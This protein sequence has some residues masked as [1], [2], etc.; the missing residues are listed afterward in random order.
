MGCNHSTKYIHQQLPSRYIAEQMIR[1]EFN[2]KTTHQFVSNHNTIVFSCTDKDKTHWVVKL[3]LSDFEGTFEEHLELAETHP[4]IQQDI[5]Y[6]FDKNNLWGQWTNLQCTVMPLYIC[7]D[8]CMTSADTDGPYSELLSPDFVRRLLLDILEQLE[9]M[10]KA[11]FMHCDV[12]IPNIVYDEKDG[13]FFLIDFDLCRRHKASQTF[14]NVLGR[15]GYVSRRAHRHYGWKERTIIRPIDDIESLIYTVYD[16]CREYLPWDGL[17]RQFNEESAESPSPMV[18][19]SLWKMKEMFIREPPKYTPKE[20]EF[21]A[22]VVARLRTYER[23]NFTVDY[24][25]LKSYLRSIQKLTP[26]LSKRS[27]R[28]LNPIVFDSLSQ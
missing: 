26:T 10:H 13:R 23:N 6:P 9:F 5:Y 17:S 21:L 22:D 12:G 1:K 24:D 14:S 28:R 3:V 18:H 11:G 25:D 20:Y 15:Y 7:I 19:I 8:L 2:M 27:L 16:L 4:F